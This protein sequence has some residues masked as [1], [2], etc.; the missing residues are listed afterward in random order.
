MRK[1]FLLIQMGVLIFL[2]SGTAMASNAEK[3]DDPMDIVHNIKDIKDLFYLLD[4]VIKNKK[5]LDY[6]LEDPTNQT[7]LTENVENTVNR[8]VN[9]LLGVDPTDIDALADRVESYL[10]SIF[11]L[12][13]FLV[14]LSFLGSVRRS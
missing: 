6:Q 10:Y 1:Y 3:T 8:G 9:L 2:F 4:M 12:V 5:N 14:I 7:R 13:V 11:A